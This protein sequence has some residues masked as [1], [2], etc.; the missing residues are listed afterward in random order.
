MSKVSPLLHESLVVAV[1][2]LGPRLHL[3]APHAERNDAGP[4]IRVRAHGS[5]ELA[6]R[7][8]GI[9]GLCGAARFIDRPRLRRAH[10]VRA[11]LPP[12]A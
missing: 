12:R 2:A 7:V 11:L 6:E 8:A 4:A 5:R 10:P 9:V 3:R 1:E